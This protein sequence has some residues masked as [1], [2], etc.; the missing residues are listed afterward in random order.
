MQGAPIHIC[1]ELQYIFAGISNIYLQ[2][3][4]IYICREL[5]LMN[6]HRIYR[7]NKNILNRCLYSLLM[8]YIWRIHLYTLY[9]FIFS[10]FWVNPISHSGLGIPY[11]GSFHDLIHIIS[12][13]SLLRLFIGRIQLYTLYMFIFSVKVVYLEDTPVYSR[14]IY[15][16]C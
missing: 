9:M 2:G 7:K 15:I 4:P 12:Y 8:L 3:A 1:R 10:G 6:L 11:R 14:Y 13:H 5:D 16:L